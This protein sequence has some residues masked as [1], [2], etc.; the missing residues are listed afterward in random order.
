[1]KRTVLGLVGMIVALSACEGGTSEPSVNVSA[2]ITD[3]SGDGGIADIVSATIDV[4]DGDM[5]VRVVL[6]PGSYQADSMLIQFN[7]DT[8][9]SAATGYT[10]ANPGHVGFGIDCMVE[11]GKYAATI[12]AARVSRW[13][14]GGFVAVANA[15]LRTITNGF[16]AT[17]PADACEDDGPALL[18]VD[19]FRQ[20]VQNGT[21]GWSTRQDWAPD[22]GQPAAPLR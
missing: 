19:A 2:S 3:A 20:V 9:E 14:N 18:K 16:E 13:N 10:S 5:I 1:M 7:L 21:A 11:V 4:A 8:D 6:T 15:T 22:P 12:R 17:L